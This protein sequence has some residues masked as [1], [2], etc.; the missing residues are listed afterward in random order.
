MF[1]WSLLDKKHNPEKLELL[2][3]KGFN[4]HERTVLILSN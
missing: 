4:K 2:M 3:N 1:L